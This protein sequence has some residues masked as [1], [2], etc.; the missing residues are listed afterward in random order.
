MLLK[1]FHD[2]EHKRKRI[3]MVD[4][5]PATPTWGHISKAPFR[6][7]QAKPV[8]SCQPIEGAAGE[9]QSARARRPPAHTTHSLTPPPPTHLTTPGSTAVSVAQ[10]R[11]RPPPMFPP[12]AH[13]HSRS[14]PPP[15]RQT[16]RRET[17]GEGAA[18]ADGHCLQQR[19]D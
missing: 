5:H 12:E 10:T 7:F 13:H 1:A 4:V 14:P 19:P 2:S 9:V 18:V 3:H 16:N 15:P 11:R 6:A 17:G 8:L